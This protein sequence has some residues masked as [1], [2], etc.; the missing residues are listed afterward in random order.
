MKFLQ[1]LINSS[2]IIYGIISII[3]L[4][5][6]FKALKIFGKLFLYLVV[7]TIL[8]IIT[9]KIYPK[10]FYSII[11][12]VQSLWSGFIFKDFRYRSIY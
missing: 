2:S 11:D 3:F 10:L 4:F 8:L 6:I 12:S 1:D 7:L 9:F 5:L